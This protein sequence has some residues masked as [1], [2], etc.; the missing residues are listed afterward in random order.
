M[1]GEHGLASHHFPF[2]VVLHSYTYTYLMFHIHQNI[3]LPNI[4]VFLRHSFHSLSK[5]NASP[6]RFP[7]LLISKW[8]QS[9]ACCA[10]S[11]VV[12]SLVP[13]SPRCLISNSEGLWVLKSR[14]TA[15]GG[16]TTAGDWRTR[17]VK[18]LQSSR[19][20]VETQQGL[21]WGEMGGKTA[22]SPI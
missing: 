18:M 22:S 21:A 19:S 9:Q 1:Y 5:E 2:K 4:I 10:Q 17:G 13:Y 8:L 11:P 20:E 12:L 3:N 6:K 14:A 15:R 16:L 7:L